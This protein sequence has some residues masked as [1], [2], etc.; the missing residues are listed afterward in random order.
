MS[1]KISSVWNVVAP[2][3]DDFAMLRWISDLFVNTCQRDLRT[4]LV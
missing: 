1:P 3:A 4:T 2:L